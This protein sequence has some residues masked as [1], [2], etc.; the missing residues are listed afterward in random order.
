[1]ISTEDAEPAFWA[2][3]VCGESMQAE[4]RRLACRNGHSFDQAKEG[5]V[6]LLLAQRKRSADPGDDRQMLLA[7][8][9]FLD[10]GYY[11]SLARRLSEICLQAR[12]AVESSF[13]LLDTGCGEGYYTGWIGAALAVD[14]RRPLRVGGTDISKDAARLAAKRHPSIH[15]AVAGNSALPVAD[16]SID[17]ALRIFAPG[18][19]AE[20]D[21]I[22]KPGGLYLTVTPGESHLFEL[23]RLIY[24]QAREH[25]APVRPLEHLRHDFRESLDFALTV[26]G[27]GDVGRLLKMTP[28]YW[29]ASRE[30]Q[31]RIA[32]LECIETRV[33]FRID[34]YRPR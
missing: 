3:P 25:E 1:M 26:K 22:L 12:Q 17:C 21:R 7:R 23:R 29:Q 18:D 16:A 15:F 20:I 8:R 5:Y 10:E 2:C 32:A 6:N 14:S 13:T 19:D 27:E 11:E 33:S 9:E 4:S 30:K 24:A 34:G 31:E 28:Y